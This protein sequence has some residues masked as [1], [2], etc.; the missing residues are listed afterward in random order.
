[1]KT[2]AVVGALILV[3][4]GFVVA[5]KQIG[6]SE[7]SGKAWAITYEVTAQAGRTPVKVSYLE[8]PDRYKRNAPNKASADVTPPWKIVVVVNSGQQAEVSATPAGNQVLTCSILLDGEK[9]LATS[10][11]APGQQVICRKQ[12]EK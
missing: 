3:V 7:I 9:V 12:M 11:A 10:T 2:F 1:M 5:I 8:N 6:W 4:G